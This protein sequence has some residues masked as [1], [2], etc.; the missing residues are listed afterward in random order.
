VGHLQPALREKEALFERSFHDAPVALLVVEGHHR[1]AL[2]LYANTT[3]S[4]LTG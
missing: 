1:P 4:R 3:L 2:F